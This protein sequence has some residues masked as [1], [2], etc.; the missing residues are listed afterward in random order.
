MIKSKFIGIVSCLTFSVLL[1]SGLFVFSNRTNHERNSFVRLY[2]PSVLLN[3]KRFDIKYNSYYI[4]GFDSSNI[5][6]GNITAPFRVLRVDSSFTNTADIKIEIEN[7]GQYPFRAIR[8]FVDP[9]F[10]YFTDGM[11]P[12]L[13]R[14]S[15]N[16]WHGKRFMYDSTFFNEAI[17]L[18]S[19]SFALRFLNPKMNQYILGKEAN[20]PPYLKYDST[21]L[22]KQID[23][24]FCTDG[25]LQYDRKSNTLLY[26]YYYRNEF[27]CMDSSLNL[28]FR[29][30][31]IDTV[32]KAKISISEINSEGSVTMSKPPLIINKNASVSDSF[33][34]IQ[35]DR[36]SKNDDVRMFEINYTVIDVYDLVGRTYRFSFYM[37][38]FKK[39]K[40]KEF[41]VY[42]NKI[43]A[44]YGQYILSYDLNSE[45]FLRKEPNI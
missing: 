5:Y 13:F 34:F 45:Y 12:V 17:P 25:M 33:L 37:P 8:V 26:V 11:V 29:G 22:E 15:I 41:R 16:N 38:P 4:A 9:P 20:V 6:F 36:L 24:I 35:S 43:V 40:M 21:L 39:T 31:T 14:G 32:S 19:T 28:L 30:K 1:V 18:S 2:P 27:L 7:A 3:E 42:N 10:F 23:G 44:M